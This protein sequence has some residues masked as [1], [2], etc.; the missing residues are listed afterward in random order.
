MESDP[1]ISVII[2]AYNEEKSIRETVDSFRKQDYPCEVIVVANN[3]KDRTYEIAKESAD[4]TL[5]FI[6]YIGVSAARNRGAE[7]AAGD[8]F[9]F[10]DADSRLS[11]GGI[12][13]IAQAV[14]EKNLGTCLGKADKKSFRGW[15]FFTFKNWT[16][17]LRIYQG[18]IDGVVFCHR[19]VFE[20]TGGFDESK[21]VAEFEDFI[22]RAKQKGAQYL[23]M[24]DSYAITSLRRFEKKGYWKTMLF[25]IRYKIRSFRKK[26][27]PMAQE[28]FTDN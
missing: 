12:R 21:K 26:E 28:Y 20:L 9:V 1:K 11:P 18:V 8:I 25:W 10:V 14:G 22:A 15:L 3:C 5:N 23:L 6:G 24:T 16:H 27:D 19:H 2:P 13:K 7:A 4:K 17:R